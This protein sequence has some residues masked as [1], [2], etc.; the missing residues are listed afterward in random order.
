MCKPET[1][2]LWKIREGLKMLGVDNEWLLSRIKMLVLLGDNQGAADELRFIDRM[3]A[4]EC[5]CEK[6][7][8]GAD[9]PGTT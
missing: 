7:D 3:L 1:C 6:G 2:D 8:E 4:A 5:P 9:H